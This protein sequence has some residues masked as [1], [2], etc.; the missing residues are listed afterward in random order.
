MKVHIDFSRRTGKTIR[1]LHGVNNSP[2]RL[3]GSLPEYKD[4][5]I[6]FVRLHDTFGLY[7][8]HVY[9][10]IP[11]LF[12]DFDADEND[13]ASYRFEFTDAYFKTLVA[14]GTQ[15]F[16]RLG[17]TIEN[18][19]K[20]RVYNIAPPPDFSKWARI[21]EHVI[22]HYNEGWNKGFHFNIQYWEIWNE[23]EN[24]RMWSGTRE[25]F[26]DL[27][28][29]T[30]LHLRKCFR[31]IK[32]GG[33]GCCGFYEIS[34]PPSELIPWFKTL[35]PWFHAFLKMVKKENLPF[36]FFSWHRYLKNSKVMIVEAEYVRKE[37]DSHGFRETESIY[38]EWNSSD[39][40]P[41]M[42]DHMKSNIGASRIAEILIAMQK[43]TSIDKAMYYDATPTRCYGGLYF[44]PSERVTPTY[45]SFKAFN[46]LY[47][48][49]NEVP[50]KIIGRAAAVLAAADE[51]SAAMMAANPG[52]REVRLD[53][54][55]THAPGRARAWITDETRTFE[56]IRFE[57]DMILPPHS[58]LLVEWNGK[59][60]GK[61]NVS[62]GTGNFGGLG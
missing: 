18:D 13:P 52:T 25:Q 16:F 37:L 41:D 1:P 20:I 49:K 38:G 39:G 53:C 21:C 62:G 28:R 31:D 5:G 6:P 58:V 54:S 3:E 40:T 32:I 15:I 55:I 46:S 8:G 33:Y 50:V 26:L 10:D 34:K 59:V 2:V 23:P 9:V 35:I 36:D 14:S 45:Y 43:Q 42:W 61:S 44:F 57:K 56:K 48:R 30:S 12:P 19:Y 17:V 7:G 11:N 27:Y 60:L 4:A 51:N 22:R 24:P 47:Q 29:I